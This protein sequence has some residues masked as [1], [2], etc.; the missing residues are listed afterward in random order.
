MTRPLGP[1]QSAAS[2]PQNT[3]EYWLCTDGAAGNVNQARALALGLKSVRSDASATPIHEIAVLNANLPLLTR[4]LAPRFSR[5]SRAELAAI[6][7]C[8]GPQPGHVAIGCGRVGAIVLDALKRRHPSLRTVQ[9]LHPRCALTRFD[10]VICPEHDH[11]RGVNV[12]SMP[13]ALT[14][15]DDAWLAHGRALAP[16]QDVQRLVLIGAPTRYAPFEPNAVLAAI[17]AMPRPGLCVSVSRRTSTAL[18]EAL[19][20]LGVRLW[21]G[22]SDGANPY[23]AWLSAAKEIW[24]TPDSVNM[25]SEASATYAH[26]KI[27]SPEC[28]RGKMAEFLHSLRARLAQNRPFRPSQQLFVTLAR[29]LD[30]QACTGARHD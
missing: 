27:F 2:A 14:A 6:P 15:I 24:V 10:W 11:A 20:T 18:I 21:R 4:L 13:G 17:A 12:L 1:E 22:P 23:Q 28:V 3:T 26:L 16:A 19:Q 25:L 29:A 7:A 8:D 30:Q 9:I 5:L